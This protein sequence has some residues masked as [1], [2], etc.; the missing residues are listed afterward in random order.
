MSTATDAGKVEYEVGT[1]VIVTDAYDE[2]DHG[3]NVELLQFDAADPSLTYRVKFDDGRETY[4]RNVALPPTTVDDIIEQ[5]ERLNTA[6]RTVRREFDLF[7]EQVR[8]VAIRVQGEQSWCLEGLNRVLEELG[9]P[10][11]MLEREFEV[12]VTVR[13]TQQATVTVTAI[14]EDHARELVDNGFDLV[15]DELDAGEWVIDEYEQATV[16]V[17]E[18]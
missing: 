3:T 15:W 17:N 4:V 18:A 2:N 9:L 14:S 13:A 11:H 5:I 12:T 7:K 6:L 1:R 16:T 10:G 8:D